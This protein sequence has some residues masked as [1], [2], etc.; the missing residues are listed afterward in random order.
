M[1]PLKPNE[2]MDFWQWI[3]QAPYTQARKREL[4]N[5]FIELHGHLP[6]KKQS[7]RVNC[8]MKTEPYLPAKG[9]LKPGRLIMS[10][11]DF[12]KVTM[13]PAMAS[14]E[15][16]VYE[17]HRHDGGY[18]FIKHVPVP[19][20]HLH[21]AALRRAGFKYI[22]TDYTSFEASFSS[23]I[24]EACEC[25]LYRHMLACSPQLSEWICRTLTGLN[26]LHFRHAMKASVRARRMSGDMCTSL[27]NGFTNLM[28]MKFA[29]Q[30]LGFD[31]VGMVEGDDGVFRIDMPNP[32]LIPPFFAR[33][34]FIVKMDVIED[35][36]LGGFCG[37][38]AAD[39]GVVKDPVKFLAT[40]GWT[41]S[42]VYGR[43]SVMM[44]L[45]RAKA[46]SAQYEL[47]HCPI[48][49]IVADRAL[50]ITQ[51]FEPRFEYDGY[52]A[53]PPS[54]SAV[55]FAPSDATRELFARLF[56]IS[57]Q[58]QLLLEAR[59]K[60]GEQLQCLEPFLNYD[61]LFVFLENRFVGP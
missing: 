17:T 12:A 9:V 28:L 5:C 44:Q 51:G 22:I 61:D 53:R 35:P 14:I 8:F 6:T 45:L 1:T 2:L 58:E 10:R 52:H 29:S 20:R 54:G 38:V 23:A 50:Q 40:F 24:M 19:E 13:G 46:L 47:P 49:R 33:L 25:Q 26:R 31:S 48:L 56:G 34:G 43:Q 4:T 16:K 18:N 36:C 3:D 41:H 60:K 21:V 42:C 39:S 15:A 57:P 7:M 59:I 30:E 37:I 27:G 11:S 32:S 55:D